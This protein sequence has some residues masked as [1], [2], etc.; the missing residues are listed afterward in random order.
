LYYFT[1]FY[2][3]Y[4][5]IIRVNLKVYAICLYIDNAIFS[6]ISVILW[7]S[8]LLAKEVGVP[9]EGH[10]PVADEL[11]Y[12]VL[13]RVH[14]AMSGVR[15]HNLSGHR[16]I[17]CWGFIYIYIYNLYILSESDS[18]LKEGVVKLVATLANFHFLPFKSSYLSLGHN[19]YNI[20]VWYIF[21]YEYL[22][23]LWNYGKIYITQIYIKLRKS[24]TWML[25][26]NLKTYI[27]ILMIII[28]M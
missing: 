8:A 16:K 13:Y 26:W 10:R 2:V 19:L 4:W 22:K 21:V 1:T 5:S 9:G 3:E 17:R 28:R 18:F 14:L 15:T 11:Y 7:R 25:A 20:T 23:L 12:I 6:N 24:N 27:P